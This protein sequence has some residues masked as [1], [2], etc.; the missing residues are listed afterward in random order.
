LE[1]AV[2]GLGAAFFAEEEGEACACFVCCE[3]SDWRCAGEGVGALAALSRS[4]AANWSCVFLDLPNAALA[5]LFKVSV[6]RF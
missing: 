3:A 5:A 4:M 1:A 2:W 6:S